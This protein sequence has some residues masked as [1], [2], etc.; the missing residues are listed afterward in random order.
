MRIY[1]TGFMGA[2]KTMVG[3]ALA[4]KLG[5]DFIDLDYEIEHTAGQT[6]E[7]I[8]ETGGESEFRKHESKILRSIDKDAA[9]I[10]TGGGCFIYNCDRMLQNGT[11][12][13]LKVPFET[14]VSRIGAETSRPLWRNAK[15]LYDEREQ[16]YESAHL[17]VDGTR[18]VETVANEIVETLRKLPPA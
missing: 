15:Q 1:L 12:V 6:I 11:V 14:L 2:G 4:Q 17:Q 13:Y 8:F 9:V 18:D 5:Y 10:A 16:I 3:R 7:S